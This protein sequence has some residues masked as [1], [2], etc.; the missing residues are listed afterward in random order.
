MGFKWAPKQELFVA[1]SW[2][3]KREDFC[4]NV[5]GSIEPEDM[6]VA[7]RAQ[8]KAGRLLTLSE[9]RKADSGAFARNAVDSISGIEPGQPI[10][11]GHHSERKHRKALERSDAAMEKASKMADMA[12]YWNYRARG[13]I[14]HANY[15]FKSSVIE[16]RI[17]RLLK[18]LRD[19]QRRLNH[20]A[21]AHEVWS[22]VTVMEDEEKRN[23]RIAALVGHRVQSGP[24]SSWET[25]NEL[26]KGDITHNE[27]LTRTLAMF[28][29]EL[30]SVDIR[31][32]MNHILNRLQFER[33]LLGEVAKFDGDL[34][35]VILQTFARTHGADLPKAK[36]SDGKW[37][38]TSDTPLPTQIGEGKSVE[39]SSEDWKELMQGLGYTVPAKAPTKAPILN[40]KATSVRVIKHGQINELEVIELSKDE[41]NA[42]YKD[43]RGVK[44]AEGGE[45]RVRICLNPKQTSIEC[46]RRDWVVVCL[47]DSKQHPVPTSAAVTVEV[48][49]V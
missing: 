32:W 13:V 27:A 46:W 17:K 29:R 19:L 6:T 44:L 30:N 22:N 43:H 14:G 26:Q 48:E 4:L 8:L 25:Y 12:T 5:A 42:I 9:K 34:T 39:R 11:V 21:F 33:D 38:L 49:G 35:A 41:F 37:I 3:P 31:R 28:E 1:P 40:F 47:T 7:E 45:F 2:T 36:C 10:L 20:A 23:K 18:E 16:G 24:L 15:K